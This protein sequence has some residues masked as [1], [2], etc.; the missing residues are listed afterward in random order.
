M[1]VAFDFGLSKIKNPYFLVP[2]I[3]SR[4][5]LATGYGVCMAVTG[6]LFPDK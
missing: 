1:D 3:A 5:V 2:Y 6:S 4:A